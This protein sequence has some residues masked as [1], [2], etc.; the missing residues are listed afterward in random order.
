MSKRVL[1]TGAFGQLGE[2]VILEL[3]PHFELCATGRVLPDDG[4]QFCQYGVMNVTNKGQVR[5]FLQNFNPDVV[6][7]LASITDVDS[8]ELN[9][10]KAW[11]VNV[12]GTENI[13]NSLRGSDTKMVFISTDYVFEGTDGPY[14]EEDIP[15]P[16]NY[17]GKSKLAAENSLRGGAQPWV[18]LRTNI[19]YG[20]SSRTSASFVNWVVN[21]LKEE[22]EI[23]VVNDQRG[24]PTW[25]AGLAEAIK[26]SIIMNIQEILNYGGA[27]FMTRFEFALRIAEVFNLDPL[28]ISPI[29]TSELNQPASRPLNSGLSTVKIEEVLGLRTY[30]VDYC[31][32][33]VKEGIVV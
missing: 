25:T 23:K 28:L 24:N 31:L 22:K 20:N 8:C 19:L 18:I 14:S 13:L 9:K 33:K 12:D 32:R 30:G 29:P 17:Y 5:E 4:F 6:V 16:V 3:Q 11:N 10:E 15:K 26:F 27:E 1:I 7:H 2:A 21:S